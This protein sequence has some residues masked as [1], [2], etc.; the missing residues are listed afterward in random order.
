MIACAQRSVEN[1]GRLLHDA[2]GDLVDEV[3]F[4]GALNSLAML[5]WKLAMPGTPDIYRGCELWDF[6]LVDPDNRRPVD[7]DRRR[8]MLDELDRP[9]LDAAALLDDWRSGAIKMHVTVSGLRARRE[10]PDLFLRGDYVP[11]EAP[12]GT[13]AF[14]RHL[15]GVWAVAVAPRLATGVTMCGRWPVG[16]ATWGDATLS[17]PDGRH[18][19]IRLADLLGTL[20]VALVVLP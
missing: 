2:F 11:L 14:A 12:T 18:T 13:F 15:D 4:F 10:H 17:L 19:E 16:T 7:F 5:T 3:M 20:P 9:D 8:R 6:S 1:D